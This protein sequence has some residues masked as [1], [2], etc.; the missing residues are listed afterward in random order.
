MKLL[1]ILVVLCL[2]SRPERRERKNNGHL[3][4]GGGGC[5]RYI[6]SYLNPGPAI[7]KHTAAQ[8]MTRSVKP[9]LKS[10]RIPAYIFTSTSQFRSFICGPEIDQKKKK[11][12]KNDSQVNSFI[13]GDRI[14]IRYRFLAV[15]SAVV[16][17]S[18]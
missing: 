5:C 8:N 7:Y 1:Q 18:L 13:T 16:A 12:K 6:H 9:F 10:Y 15:T 14:S 4:K 11:K 3:L 2:V 17:P